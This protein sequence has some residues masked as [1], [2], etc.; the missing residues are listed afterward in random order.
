MQKKLK[1]YTKNYGVDVVINMLE[2]A[3]I[4]KGLNLL[5]PNGRY[6][7]IAMVGLRM[8]SYSTYPI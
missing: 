5:A 2:G 8:Q 1:K 4:Q 6:V 7:E 3:D